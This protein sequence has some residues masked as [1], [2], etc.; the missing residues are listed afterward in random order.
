MAGAQ[1]NATFF[2]ME[3]FWSTTYGGDGMDNILT[4][5]TTNVHIGIQSVWQLC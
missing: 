2:K 5:L 1:D 4:Q 3:V